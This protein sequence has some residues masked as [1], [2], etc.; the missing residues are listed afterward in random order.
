M[1]GKMQIFF[2]SLIMIGV[3]FMGCMADNNTGNEGNIFTGQWSIDRG[4]TTE[5]Y[6][7]SLTEFEFFSNGSI[8]IGFMKGTY[9][10]TDQMLYVN[11]SNVFT[12]EYT[13]SFPD[14]SILVLNF[15]EYH[16]TYVKTN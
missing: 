1:E 12:F 10:F 7:P 4:N 15:E 14:D 5:G 2:L 9:E 6:R 13:Y 8:D 16:A 3:F 11:F